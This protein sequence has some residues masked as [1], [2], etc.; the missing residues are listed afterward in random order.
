V[1]L[2]VNPENVFRARNVLACSRSRR[3][4]NQGQG[5]SDLCHRSSDAGIDANAMSFSSAI[6]F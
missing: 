3:R 2:Y 5:K 6:G 4:R 1:P